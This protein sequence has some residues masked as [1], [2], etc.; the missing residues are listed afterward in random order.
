MAD[1]WAARDRFFQAR[2]L[3]GLRHSMQLVFLV[4][5]SAFSMLS[6]LL[7]AWWLQARQQRREQAALAAEMSRQVQERYEAYLDL[8]DRIGGAIDV[9]DQQESGLLRGITE[10]NERIR[11]LEAALSGIDAASGDIAQL[12]AARVEELFG[13]QAGEQ[14]C[15]ED[16]LNDWQE[17]SF[18]LQNEKQAEISRQSNSIDALAERVRSLEPAASRLEILK[19]EFD[20][21]SGAHRD[22]SIDVELKVEENLRFSMCVE[23]LQAELEIRNAQVGT[24]ESQVK[25]MQTDA[26]LAEALSR[27]FEEL[28]VEVVTLRTQCVDRRDALEVAGQ[29]LET[30]GS[31]LAQARVDI[32]RIQNELE[33]TRE[34]LHEQV[35]IGK[36]LAGDLLER[37]TQVAE[38]EHGIE[39]SSQA[40]AARAQAFEVLQKQLETDSVK[41]RLERDALDGQFSGAQ[42]ELSEAR[43]QI[44]AITV[45]HTA[46]VNEL[47][48]CQEALAESESTAKSMQ[49]EREQALAQLEEQRDELFAAASSSPKAT[50]DLEELQQHFEKV[51]TRRDQA[52]T[53]LTGRSRDLSALVLR[54]QEESAQASALAA[55]SEDE[56]SAARAT[57]QERDSEFE[58]ARVELVGAREELDALRGELDASG[59]SESQAQMEALQ[60]EL[61]NANQK[62]AGFEQQF[63]GSEVQA[64]GWKDR[65][66]EVEKA[67]KQLIAEKAKG[68]KDHRRAEKGLASSRA[69]LE[70]LQSVGAQ[71]ESELVASIQGLEERLDTSRVSENSATVSR[72]IAEDE[73]AQSIKGRTKA[74]KQVAREKAKLER[75]LAAKLHALDAAKQA[76][77]DTRAEL[78]A[79]LKQREKEYRAKQREL[80]RSEKS[81]E[82]L[83]AKFDQ[84]LTKA[85]TQ[86]EKKCSKLEASL[87]KQARKFVQ[88]SQQLSKALEDADHERATSKAVVEEQRAEAELLRD[89]LNKQGQSF[90]ELQHMHEDALREQ[91]ELQSALDERDRS[92]VTLEARVEELRD[93]VSEASEQVTGRQGEIVSLMRSL[94]D[95]QSEVDA[96]RAALAEKDS[97]IDAS[98]MLFGQLDAG[99]DELGE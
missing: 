5:T 6:G 61:A 76:V 75:Q 96:Q 91:A 93:E 79:Q 2:S 66:Q 48:R 25:E 8:E 35:S 60:V 11:A 40:T 95:T 54:L 16:E 87:A 67:S 82:S 26:M 59:S 56:L 27:R 94:D 4:I 36:S 92:V 23:E 28:E 65:C 68:D 45:E 30:T 15:F 85:N 33:S 44:E 31:N 14:T 71:R 20:D 19:Q 55:A 86:A 10:Q 52:E 53:E 58:T 17:R 51:Q 49:A 97:A 43:D 29:S 69:E 24:L 47:L 57:L 38:L 78:R 98:K 46:S 89:L 88:A 90:D 18:R 73:G 72:A 39:R 41:L 77:K 3:D 34:E 83:Q 9:L 81:I 13:Q 64:A 21:L 74:N 50:Q 70:E 22:Q 7:F 84:Q 42:T 32:E 62:A 80:A 99:A 37:E 12:E 1:G 63:H